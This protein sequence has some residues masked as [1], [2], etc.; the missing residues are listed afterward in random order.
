MLPNKFPK[1][2]FDSHSHVNFEGFDGK[3]E[4]II[5]QMKQN[6]VE[7]AL[8]MAANLE[9]SRKSLELSKKYQKIKSFV[10]IDP[11][12]FVPGSDLFEGLDKDDSY[13]EENYEVI[14][15]MAKDNPV[16]V[17]GIG[18]T[19][20]DHYWLTNNKDRD[21]VS[22][23]DRIMES[24]SNKSKDLQEKLFRMHLEIAKELKLPL[25]IH[26]RGAERLCLEIV[27]KYNCN[28]IFHSFTGDY[29]TAKDILD[30]GWNL[31]I[32]GIITFKNAQSLREMYKK[33]FGNIKDFSPEDFYN[34]GIYFETDA[35]F[36]SPEGK[37]GEIN[38]PAA[39]RNIFEQ[40][41]QFLRT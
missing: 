16:E 40:F 20:I 24:D 34:K 18:E 15:K 31:G 32:N 17:F 6:G 26:S 22:D 5:E 13:F 29:E 38:T 1:T 2:L 25:S 10:G 35:P 37:R 23:K 7:M 39:T 41:V 14:K 11:E 33:L 21:R 8:D 36:L 30:A 19:G 3:I 27:K 9:G 12:V 4:Q 28:G